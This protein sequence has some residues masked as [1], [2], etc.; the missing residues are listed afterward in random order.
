MDLSRSMHQPADTDSMNDEENDN[1]FQLSDGLRWYLVDAQE[2]RPGAPATPGLGK[3]TVAANNVEAMADIHT[4]ARAGGK[5]KGR[6][7]TNGMEG[8]SK[9]LSKSLESRRSSTGSKK[10]LPL[11]IA[12]GKVHLNASALASETN[13]PRAVA[14]ETPTGTSPTLGGLVG[15]IGASNIAPQQGQGPHG[16]GSSREQSAPEGGN[17][18]QADVDDGPKTPEVQ[19]EHGG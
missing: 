8:V 2:D 14:P 10:A 5:D 6:N 9:S 18:K 3:S 7:S 17:W 1:P 12:G 4:H 13:S 16:E 15:P 19:T 11:A